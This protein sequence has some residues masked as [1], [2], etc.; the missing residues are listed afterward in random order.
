MVEA[1]RLQKGNPISPPWLVEYI[2]AFLRTRSIFR[3]WPKS[4]EAFGRCGLS[5]TLGHVDTSG[6]SSP[7]SPTAQTQ[8]L[9]RLR[10]LGFRTESP[11]SA[12]AD[13]GMLESHTAG[14]VSD[15]E[16]GREVLEEEEEDEGVVKN[17]G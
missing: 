9:V 13:Q 7:A 11:E 17:H 2:T 5:S 8:T 6:A 10:V 12:E 14:L 1:T 16:V 3:C 15:V 4:V